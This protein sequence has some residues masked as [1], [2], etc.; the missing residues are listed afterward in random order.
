M[1][2]PGVLNN[3][4]RLCATNISG[5][6]AL[7]RNGVLVNQATDTTYTNGSPGIG[8]DYTTSN[9]YNQDYGFSS[10]RAGLP[11]TPINGS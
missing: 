6:L 11:D 9:E 5:T 4:D 3:G 2:T 8:F 1:V 7:Y 10:F